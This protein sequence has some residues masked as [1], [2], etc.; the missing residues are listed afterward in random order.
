MSIKFEN[1]SYVYG[2]GTHQKTAVLNNL[3][4]E[5]EYGKIYGM[6][7]ATG[8]GKTTAIQLINGLLKPTKGKIVIEQTVGEG[9][10]IK[11]QRKAK[12]ISVYEAV[13]GTGISVKLWR[14]LE[15][16]KTPIDKK[17]ISVMLKKLNIS[18]KDFNKNCF[19]KTLQIKRELISQHSG[20]DTTR[21]KFVNDFLIRP[22]DFFANFYR[23]TIGNFITGKKI[24]LIRTNIGLV[25]QFAE[26][27]LFADT[28][29]K[30]IAFGPKNYKVPKEEVEKRVKKYI[31]IV[32]LSEKLLDKSPFD[33][34]GG[35]KRRV[36][37]AGVLAMEPDVLIF[38]EPIAGLDPKGEQLMMELFKY[39]NKEL[40][41]TIIMI[42]HNMDHVLEICDKVIIMEK[43][44]F[45]EFIT[46][47]ELFDSEEKVEKYGLL[48]PLLYKFARQVSKE[49][50]GFKIQTAKTLNEFKEE[51][52]SFL[53]KN[54][55]EESSGG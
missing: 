7:G 37:I 5:L 38:D 41:K 31:K 2:I 24:K 55:K 32:G 54:R 20:S 30:D 48:P 47:K 23:K 6:I 15:R 25:F 53:I 21:Q 12:K 43:G 26:Y 1:A 14:N 42:T 45:K 11:K 17:T 19:Q 13:K 22:L 3:N 8:C 49:I 29:A 10:S 4:L 34:S 36:A 16:G 39:L 44:S 28:I 9:L 35:Q 51:L 40:G 52:K 33:L 18:K 50:K 46:P 27:Q